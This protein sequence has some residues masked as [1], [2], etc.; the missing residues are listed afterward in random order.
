MGME[1]NVAKALGASLVLWSELSINE[2]LGG[3]QNLT[4]SIHKTDIEKCPQHRLRAL[5]GRRPTGELPEVARLPL[6]GQPLAL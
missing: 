3:R 5:L 4:D 1:M 2:L 6:T